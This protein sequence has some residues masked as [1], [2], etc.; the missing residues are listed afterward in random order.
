[1]ALRRATVKQS[2]RQ[3]PEAT[4]EAE[5]VDPK[6]LALILGVGVFLALFSDTAMYIVLPV[7]MER[8]GITLAQVGLMLA[9]NRLVRIPLNG[10]GGLLV[11][12]LPRR[13][14][15]LAAQVIGVIASLA[16][17]VTGFWPL[18]IGRMLWGISWIGLWIAGN[19]ALLDAAPPESRGNLSGQFHL[20][21]F[22]GF[23]GGSL[24]GGLLND[25]FSYEGT[26]LVCAALGVL[27][28]LLW[29][30]KLP[31][32]AHLPHP[33]PQP[34][35]GRAGGDD[36]PRLRR[37]PLITAMLLMALNWMVYLG[38]I[39]TTL[40]LLL[41]EKVGESLTLGSILLPLTTLSGLAFAGKHVLSMLASPVT[42]AISDR[43]GDRWGL[44]TFSL[45][46][47]SATLVLAARAEGLLVIAAILPGAITHSI[48][49]TQSTA[50]IGDLV[51]HRRRP[52]VLGWFN[53]VADTGSSLGPL[54]AYAFIS[55]GWPI[56]AILLL[57]AVLLALMSPWTV[58]LAIRE[59][60]APAFA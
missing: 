48:L 30:W 7:N 1:M 25:W 23:S 42:G 45:L 19:A 17:L 56:S 5:R 59:R 35:P 40:T 31:E 3:A 44:I 33:E 38:F 34:Q 26:F 22:A 11:E 15:L 4:G 29:W 21:I 60:R 39:S 14:V 27:G 43:L 51:P 16:Y 55:G 18:L 8:A 28:W 24:V 54:V 50:L 32:T 47:G 52:R 37:L 2:D 9:A 10:P 36:A 41:L 13:R 58:W 6:R 57:A 53:T 49:Q 20:W 46:L 12:R